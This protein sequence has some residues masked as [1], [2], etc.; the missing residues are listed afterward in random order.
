MSNFYAVSR[1]NYFRVIDEAAFKQW[2]ASL[3]EVEAYPQKDL[4]C[5]ISNSEDGTF[6]RL[7]AEG[8]ERDFLGE[9]S[10]HLAPGSVAVR[11]EIG[12]EKQRYLSGFADAINS[13]GKRVEVSINDIYQLAEDELRGEVTRA[14][15]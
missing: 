3:S 1:T 13:E 8:K 6:S 7:D 15:Y 14:E 11:L 2:V 12:N 4:F 10:K 5:L 9:L